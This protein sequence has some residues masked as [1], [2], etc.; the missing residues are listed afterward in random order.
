MGALKFSRLVR[1]AALS[2]V[3]AIVGAGC[4]GG[5]GEQPTPT[6]GASSSAPP[7]G[8]GAWDPMSWTPTV[9]ITAV[10][11]TAEEKMASH[12]RRLDK[13]AEYEKI[14]PVP[15][16]EIVRWIENGTEYGPVMAAC[17]TDA[18]FRSEGDAVGGVQYLDEVPEAQEKA[19]HLAYY[20][21]AAK[22][23]LDPVYLTEW[24]S[25]QLGLLYD[26]WEQ[27]FIPCLAAHGLKID[28]SSKPTRE[29]YVARFHTP[30]RASWWPSD[31]LATMPEKERAAIEAS[32]PGY[33]PDAVFY[34]TP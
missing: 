31:T 33:P 17:L 15:D 14:S 9:K 29:S 22:Y 13:M 4:A 3:V 20:V 5:E 8:P 10:S 26:Y 24:T 1:V 7:S 28:E 12:L 2:A 27:Y 34:G 32:C 16:V 19:L 11:L 30:E 23:P 6:G 25:E 21:C 18:G